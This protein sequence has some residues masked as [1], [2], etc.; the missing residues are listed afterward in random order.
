MRP[1]SWV[2]GAK[3]LVCQGSSLFGGGMDAPAPHLRGR[4][5]GFCGFWPL[6]LSIRCVMRMSARNLFG[7]TAPRPRP[8]GGG[9]GPGAGGKKKPKEW[10]RLQANPRV[11]L[12][13][14]AA[15]R[16]IRQV[17]S[18]TP[19]SHP[20]G[21]L[22][23]AHGVIETRRRTSLRRIRRLDGERQSTGKSINMLQRQGLK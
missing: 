4:C 1:G 3:N 12:F 2:S 23:C 22:R 15:F 7:L 21:I 19:A 16:A 10:R 8:G 18:P 20:L 9:V 13:N 5:T 6:I 14:D 11:K 17:P